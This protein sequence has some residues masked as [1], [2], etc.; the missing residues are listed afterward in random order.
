MSTSHFDRPSYTFSPELITTEDRQFP[1]EKI[2]QIPTTDVI[3]PAKLYELHPLCPFQLRI[4][5]S[6]SA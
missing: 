1:R 3:E 4:E 2:D 5:L 6:I